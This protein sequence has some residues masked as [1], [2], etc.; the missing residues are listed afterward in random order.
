MMRF[1]DICNVEF[2]SVMQRCELCT[3]SKCFEALLSQSC[4]SFLVGF[5]LCLVLFSKNVVFF[6]FQGSR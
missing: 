2:A 3:F 1:V 4:P 5:L 6:L